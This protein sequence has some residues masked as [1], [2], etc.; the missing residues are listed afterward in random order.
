MF[1]G[2]FIYFSQMEG[3]VD[4]SCFNWAL[5]S[6]IGPLIFPLGNSLFPTLPCGLGGVWFL[7][8]N[9]IDALN[10]TMLCF[11]GLTCVHC[12]MFRGI[13]GLYPL[14]ASSTPLLQLWQPQMSANIV[15]CPLGVREDVIAPLENNWGRS[16]LSPAPNLGKQLRPCHLLISQPWP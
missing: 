2:G 11:G 15:R 14:D 1:R 6:R 7:K 9:T 5:S 12:K 3:M 10:Q 8:Y 4:I 16:I 13:S